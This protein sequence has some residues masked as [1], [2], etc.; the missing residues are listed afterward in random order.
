L[1]KHKVDELY[2]AGIF[3][4]CCVYFTGA[5]AAMRGI[6]PFII[7]DAVASPSKERTRMNIENFKIFM[8]PAITTRKLLDQLHTEAVVRKQKPSGK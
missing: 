3:A 1:H 8:G 4:G 7:S 5:D 6:Q 2:L